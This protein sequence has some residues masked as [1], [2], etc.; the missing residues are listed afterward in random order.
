[1]NMRRKG[2]QLLS[3]EMIMASG[4]HDR[5]NTYGE[6]WMDKGEKWIGYEG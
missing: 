5:F 4:R 2:K 1:M 6:G 3:S